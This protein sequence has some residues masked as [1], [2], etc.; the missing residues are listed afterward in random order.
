ML[1][2]SIIFGSAPLALGYSLY[3][4][5]RATTNRPLT[6]IAIALAVLAALFVAWAIVAATVSFVRS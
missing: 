3:A 4:R 5:T 1:G 2:P 6:Y